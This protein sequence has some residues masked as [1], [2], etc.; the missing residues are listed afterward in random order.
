M[1]NQFCSICNACGCGVP[2]FEVAGKYFCSSH[3]PTNSSISGNDA[4]LLTPQQKITI[5]NGQ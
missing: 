1:A 2:I 4:Q 3:R 5:A